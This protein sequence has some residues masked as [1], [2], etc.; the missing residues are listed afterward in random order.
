MWLGRCACGRDIVVPTPVIVAIVRARALL[1]GRRLTGASSER[2]GHWFYGVLGLMLGVL[3]GLLVAPVE[4]P[5]ERPVYLGDF[6][7]AQD[8]NR[9]AARLGCP[10]VEAVDGELLSDARRALRRCLRDR[11]GRTDSR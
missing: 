3:L 10:Q 7:M 6:V 4:R 2:A 11:D 8:F 5:A 9:L 1:R